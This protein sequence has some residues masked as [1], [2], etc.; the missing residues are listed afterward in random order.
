MAMSVIY[1]N[2]PGGDCVADP[3]A[4]ESV[5]D[6]CRFH[7]QV[8]DYDRTSSEKRALKGRWRKER[9]RTVQSKVTA[10]VTNRTCTADEFI[11]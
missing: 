6:F 5:E 9:T 2:L 1:V 8:E 3:K 7:R 10:I 4:L 11:W